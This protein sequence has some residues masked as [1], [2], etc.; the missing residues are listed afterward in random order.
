MIWRWRHILPI[1]FIIICS[2]LTVI[3]FGY[4]L[5]A[6]LGLPW[7]FVMSFING[8]LYALFPHLP[9]WVGLATGLI[10]PLVVNVVLLYF[11]GRNLEKHK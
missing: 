1:I 3:P 6:L 4:V 9:G 8:P 7:T 5:I 11:A 10:L 2:L